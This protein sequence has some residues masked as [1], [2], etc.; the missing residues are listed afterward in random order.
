MI[1][2]DHSQ[3]D[4]LRPAPKPAFD[5]AVVAELS[6]L[7]ELSALA[8]A[9]SEEQLSRDSSEK[10]ARL[11]GARRFAVLSGLP[12]DRRLVSAIGFSAPGDA[13]RAIASSAGSPNALS[14]VF[15]EGE[16]EQVSVFFEQSRPVAERA[17]RLYSVLARRIDERLSAFRLDARRRQAEECLRESE[18]KY[19]LFVEQA[20][21]VVFTLSPD[22]SLSYASPSWT[23][24]LGFSPGEVVGKSFADFVHPDDLSS[25]AD[26][27]R[28]IFESAVAADRVSYRVRHKDG[29]FRWHSASGS[30]ILGPDGRV[31]SVVG[32]ARDVT[33][34]KLADEKLLH[35][36]NLMRY[37]IEHSQSAIA[38][39]DRELR[40]LYVSR[41]YL[42]EYRVAERDV[43]GKHHYEVFPNL[44]Q[45]WRDAHARA[46]AGEILSSNGDP[47]VRD[48]GSIEWTRWE[49]RPWFEADG[50]VGGIVVY[51]QLITDQRRMEAALRDRTRD[52]ETKNRQVECLFALSR[53]I[54]NCGDD[55]SAVFAEAARLLQNALARTS[56]PV[57]SI[58][59]DEPTPATPA[60]PAET[61]CDVFANGVRRGAIRIAC[62]H[63]PLPCNLAA[64][65]LALVSAVAEQLGHLLERIDALSVAR[66][67]QLRLIQDDKLTS[68]GT[69]VAGIAHEINNPVNNVMLNASLLRDFLSDVLPV[70]DAHRQSSGDFSAGGLPYS[71]MREVV[72]NLLHG[73]LESSDRIKHITADIRD[74]ASSRP[75]SEE[76]SASVNVAVSAAL[77]LCAH[78]DKRF[79]DRAKISLAESLPKT[80]CSARRLEQIV[81]NLV[82]NAWQSLRHPDACIFVSS[83]LDPSDGM[84]VVEV[85]DEGCGMPPDVL[86]RVMDPF[87]TTR[88]D[89]GGT[90]LGLYVAGNVAESVGGRLEFDSSVGLGT[91]ARLRLPALSQS[92]KEPSP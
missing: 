88:R 55:K 24:I 60:N 72:P 12:P 19:R 45:K 30:P 84:I 16:P 10:V 92:P 62:P 27:V 89:Q 3:D 28:R 6:I 73:I 2:P 29:S 85:R 77:R 42:Q 90:G 31:R 9:E 82:Q 67:R 80:P 86:A 8:F 56:P 91:T 51:T 76:E 58:A 38:V 83:R 63:G 20:N 39:H 48:D 64:D 54:E 13:D 14:I 52:L 41:R 1:P 33:D 46:L 49:C 17:R 36:R 61:S 21:D 7:H 23:R 70:L 81:I 74:A 57:V 4:A 78:M 59:V 11:F 32:I 66:E 47:F 71:E 22:G 35:S 75:E 43:V 87:F 25:C 5:Y 79:R 34:Q 26:A 40:Y 50:S 15:S 37:V 44:P 18:E 53:A 69:M 68:L 65:D